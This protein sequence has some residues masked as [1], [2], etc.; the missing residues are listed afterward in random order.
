MSRDSLAADLAPLPRHPEIGPFL[1]PIG[2]DETLRVKHNPSAWNA[3]ADVLFVDQPVGSGLTTG[4]PNITSEAD[5]AREF[6]GFFDG[7]LDVFPEY[8]SKKIV[9]AGQG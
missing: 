4:Q 7:F 8:K 5:L 6:R 9:L 1:L 3:F 2:A